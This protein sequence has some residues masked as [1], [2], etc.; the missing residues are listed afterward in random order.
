MI[1]PPAEGVMVSEATPC[2][3]HHHA[4]HGQSDASV[5][6]LA[7]VH[8]NADRAG[9]PG[10][11]HCEGKAGSAGDEG[12][13]GGLGPSS[14]TVRGDTLVAPTPEHLGALRRH[15]KV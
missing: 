5:D 10:L 11:S 4:E 3:Q 13:S 8:A 14:W 6:T 9:T 12:A 2:I 1:G 7:D 15:L